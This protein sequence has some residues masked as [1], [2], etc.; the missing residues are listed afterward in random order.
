MNN[1]E[2]LQTQTEYYNY[3]LLNK[4]LIDRSVTSSTVYVASAKE[5]IDLCAS[6]LYGVLSTHPDLKEGS[7]FTKYNPNQLIRMQK[8]IL[9]KY[10]VSTS[11]SSTIGCP[12]W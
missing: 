12:P 11:S 10:G 1:L 3:N 5:D 8:I 9:R 2:A 6:D 7:R 4:I